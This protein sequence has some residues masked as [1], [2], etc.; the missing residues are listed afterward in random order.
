MVTIEEN[1]RNMVAHLDAASQASADPP[2][3]PRIQTTNIVRTGR[4][5]RPR[6]EYDQDLL[7][8]ALEMRGP[9]HIAQVFGGSART[10]RRRALE[11]GLVEPGPPVYVDYEAEDGSTFRVYTSSTAAMSDLTDIEL[12]NI[13]RHIVEVF[14]SFGRR[15]I[16]GHL[17]HMG[18]RIPRER[19]RAS[20]LRV[21]GPPIMAFGVRRIERR[22]YSVPGPNSLAHHDGQ[23]GQFGWIVSC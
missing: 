7:Q 14:P 18:H 13:V 17:R 11:Y 19:L 3:M 9:T 6:I 15:M 10:V 23:H 2:E 8:T 20:Y 12:D 5:G 22:V 1:I 21:H 4:Q 16:D